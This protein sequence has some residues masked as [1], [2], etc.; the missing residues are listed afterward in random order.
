MI[1]ETSENISG[2]GF[3][4]IFDA[5]NYATFVLEQYPDFIP[6]SPQMSSRDQKHMTLVF[7]F[8]FHHQR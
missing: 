3:N 2:S 7:T 1:V 5:L 8:S 4:Y 6:V